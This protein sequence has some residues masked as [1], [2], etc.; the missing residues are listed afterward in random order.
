MVKLMQHRH[1]YTHARTHAR[2]HTHTHSKHPTTSTLTHQEEKHCH[3]V[4]S[5]I[6]LY[7]KSGKE[8]DCYGNRWDAVEKVPRKSGHPVGGRVDTTDKLKVFGLGAKGRGKEGGAQDKTPLQ[9]NLR[10]HQNE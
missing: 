10:I 6:L 5:I 3:E 8:D 4:Y 1:A 7:L 2:T 9:T